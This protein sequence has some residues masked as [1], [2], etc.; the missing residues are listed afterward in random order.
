MRQ[1]INATTL[2]SPLLTGSQNFTS[3]GG[4][5]FSFSINA[6]GQFVTQGNITARI[7]QPDVLLPNGVVH[8][9][10]NVFLNTNTDGN[11]AASA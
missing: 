10:D 7:I 6:T 2:Y 5:T 11:A 4:E 1:L 9:V 8:I 3:Q